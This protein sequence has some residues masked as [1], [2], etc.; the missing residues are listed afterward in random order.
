MSFAKYYEDDL[1]ISEER[2]ML[3]QQPTEPL[4]VYRS[5]RGI[6]NRAYPSA[7]KIKE[8]EPRMAKRRA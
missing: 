8:T 4:P 3:R 5:A 2:H 6:G 1:E 7:V